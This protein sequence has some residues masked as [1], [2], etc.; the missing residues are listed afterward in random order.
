MDEKP[1]SKAAPKVE[2]KIK[3]I[4]A[5]L[6]RRA[7]A[8]KAPPPQKK[9]E[10]PSKPPPPARAV[11][12][13]RTGLQLLANLGFG[14]LTSD[15]A[16]S[17]GKAVA[18]FTPSIGIG[19]GVQHRPLRFLSYGARLNWSA[20]G[21]ELL[22]STTG[23]YFEGAVL[24]EFYPIAIFM[25]SSRFD[26]Y[27]GLGVGWGHFQ[28]DQSSSYWAFRGPTLH[29]STGLQV[30]VS[31]WLSLGVALQYKHAFWID[32]CADGNCTAV[33]DLPSKIRDSLPGLFFL[34]AEG[35]FH[36]L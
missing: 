5:E 31:R 27:V 23:W 19:F 18:S 21:V 12:Y 2:E 29:I 34:A 32:S 11:K 8:D 24:A 10:P 15:L 30:F 26:P 36:L 25:P 9:P 17:N 7:R 22:P 20:I 13:K 4:E 14:A 33:S 16:D 28:M 3:E 6:A 1:D 35:A